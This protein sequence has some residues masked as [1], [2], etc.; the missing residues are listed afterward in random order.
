LLLEVLRKLQLLLK[1]GCIGGDAFRVVLPG[2]SGDAIEA[3]NK[4]KHCGS[5]LFK[6]TAV[7]AAKTRSRCMLQVDAVML[8]LL[9]CCK[10]LQW[11]LSST[12]R[13]SATLVRSSRSAK[14]SSDFLNAWAL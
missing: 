12:G 5:T 1:L 2:E 13:P 9:N 4:L 14:R 7:E 10:G 8:V 6:A 3:F 11:H